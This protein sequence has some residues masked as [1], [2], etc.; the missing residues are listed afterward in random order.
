MTRHAGIG[1]LAAVSVAAGGCYN[2]QPAALTPTPVAGTYLVA[3]LSDSGSISLTRYLG[4]EAQQVGG[5]W[6][7][8][9][10]DSLQLSVTKIVTMR[11]DEL[12]WQGESVTLPVPFITSLQARRLAKGRT[13]LLAAIGVAAVI[14]AT[15]TFEILGKAGSVGP[16]GGGPRPQ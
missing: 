4:P 8:S 9:D 2:Y 5:Q 15:A 12:S 1:I 7:R 13:G 14:A 3:T 16:P 10:K 11:G 6:L